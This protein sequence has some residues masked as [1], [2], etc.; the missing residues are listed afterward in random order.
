MRKKVISLFLLS[1]LQFVTASCDIC[2]C[3]SR[4]IFKKT[5]TEIKLTTLNRSGFQ[6]SFTD[7][8]IPKNA[9]GLEIFMESDEKQIANKRYNLNLGSFGFNSALDC[10]CPDPD[11]LLI[12][13][14]AAI[15]IFVRSTLPNIDIEVTNN[16][17]ITD[18]REN[19]LPFLT[20]FQNLNSE[21]DIYRSRDIFR[22][23]LS[24]LSSIPDASIFTLNVPLE[25]GKIISKTTS[26]ITLI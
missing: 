10:S 6:S 1:A 12:D 7:N 5:C 26:T 4:S 24:E 11:Y 20:Y 13:P 16:F 8:N 17:T 25:S 21:D 14:I 23:A 15:Q 3:G 19:T 22:L 18:F 9:F 2:D